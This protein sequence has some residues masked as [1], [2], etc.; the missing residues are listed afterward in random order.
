MTTICWKDNVLAVDS[1][2]TTGTNV[3]YRESKIYVIANMVVS[4]SGD[5]D[6]CDTFLAWIKDG[7]KTETYPF[8]AKSPDF[9]GILLTK[10]GL[11]SFSNT[12][13]GK[14]YK[15]RN[16]EAWGSGSDYCRGVM[17]MGANAHEAVEKTCDYCIYT[18][19]PVYSIS[20]KQLVK[21]PQEFEG[22]WEGT[23]NDNRPNGTKKGGKV[24][25][26]RTASR[27]QS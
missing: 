21:L 14:G 15:I 5:G 17:D 22:L 3:G 9:G 20:T 6:A 25:R 2:V 19:R 4:A 8:T 13:K 10:D 12:C 7:A 1:Q 26:R 23:Y 27:V 18:G 24:N 16:H 11:F